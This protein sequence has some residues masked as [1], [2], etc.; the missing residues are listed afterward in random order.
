[1][2]RKAFPNVMEQPVMWGRHREIHQTDEYKAIVNADTGKIFSIVSKDYRL[3][4]HE[5]AIEQAEAAIQGNPALG[6]YRVVTG[7]YND[8]GRM[9]RKY[10]FPEI[11]VKIQEGDMVNPELQLFNSYDTS[12]PFIVILGAFRFIC[13]NGL[14]IGKKYLQLKKRH[15]FNFDEIDLKKQVSTA[16]NRF[17]LQTNQWKAWASRR[18]APSTSK[19]VMKGMKFGKK[20][21]DEIEQRIIQE[22]KGFDDGFPIIS[23]W[24]F[25]NVLTW[26]ISHRAVS[27]NHRVEMEKRLR[28][29]I[30]TY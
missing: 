16:L 9:R 11:E 12:W 15:I 25:Y 1:M 3:I 13:T 24:A 20:A 27:L 19:K 2:Q 26:Y 6:K 8:G 4:R 14:V 17:E 7:F 10:I 30:R 22:S 28:K 23:L 21:L 5:K 29:A 18:L